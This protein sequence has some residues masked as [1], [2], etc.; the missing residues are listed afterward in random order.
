[1]NAQ[2][3]N[4]SIQRRSVDGQML[5]EA[6]AS[7]WQGLLSYGETYTQAY[8]E[9]IDAIETAMQLNGELGHQ[10]PQPAARSPEASG[11]LMLRL[12]RSLHGA[13][14][15]AA[16]GEGTSLNQWI[17][18]VLSFHQGSRFGAEHGDQIWHSVKPV[19]QLARA[20]LQVI[21][22]GRSDPIWGP[23]LQSAN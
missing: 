13:L 2:D 7:E 12:P 21:K 3:Y 22:G 6:S 19:R 5:F 1:M 10:D 9:I 8:E 17:C 16:E 23:A 18:A 14:S 20:N 4:I 15:A 11:K